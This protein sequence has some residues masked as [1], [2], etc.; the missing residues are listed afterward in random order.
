M[1]DDRSLEEG[2]PLAGREE[3]TAETQEASSLWAEASGVGTKAFCRRFSKSQTYRLPSNKPAQTISGRPSQ[4]ERISSESHLVLFSLLPRLQPLPAFEKNKAENEIKA[5]PL[6]AVNLASN[7]TFF[8]AGCA[9]FPIS[10]L[11]INEGSSRRI[12]PVSRPEPNHL[13]QPSGVACRSQIP[14]RAQS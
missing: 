10:C 13:G 1:Y 8:Q 6:I 9:A 4:S 7:A 2:F 12:F 3:Q 14:S 5:R 11:H